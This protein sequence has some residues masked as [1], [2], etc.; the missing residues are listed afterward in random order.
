MRFFIIIAILLSTQLQAAKFVFK[1][2]PEKVQINKNNVDKNKEKIENKTNIIESKSVKNN[3]IILKGAKGAGRT[4]FSILQDNRNSKNGVYTISPS[5]IPFNAYCD[6]ENGGWSLVASQ[7]E[8]ELLDKNIYSINEHNFGHL[9]KSFRLGNEIINSIRPY[10]SWKITDNSN[11][12]YFNPNCIINWNNSLD[13]KNSEFCNTGFKDELFNEKI[14]DSTISNYSNGIGMSNEGKFC[15]IR[16]YLSRDIF[17]R[18]NKKVITKG[19]A[20]N[21][22]GNTKG[23]IKLWFK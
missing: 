12:V 9:D 5:N 18:N 21:C 3:F 7:V 10:F 8:V 1:T 15:S 6:M 2:D 14:S 4:C 11:S 17:D 13:N 16:M 20:F 22:E 23:S 19:T